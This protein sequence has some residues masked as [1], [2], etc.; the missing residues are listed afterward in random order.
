MRVLQMGAVATSLYD[1]AANFNALLS[2]SAR[3]TGRLWLTIMR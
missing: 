3:K 2:L 1:F